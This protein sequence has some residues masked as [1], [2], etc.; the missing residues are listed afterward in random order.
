MDALTFIDLHASYD[1]PPLSVRGYVHL[2]PVARNHTDVMQAKLA[3][4]M[5]QNQFSAREANFKSKRRKRFFYYAFFPRK[6]F[7]LRA[8]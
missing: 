6:T 8:H 7:G 5:S 3:G 4:Q 2:D 1:P